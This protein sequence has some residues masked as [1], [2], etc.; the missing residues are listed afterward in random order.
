MRSGIGYDIHKLVEGREMFL[1]GVKI[2]FELGLLGHSDADVLLH[3][4]CDAL[5]GAA[6]RGDIGWH[7]P[8]S[9]VKYK[10]I[11]SL[12]LLERVKDII[13]PQYKIIN[14]DSVIVAEKPRLSGYIDEMKV[15]IA[16]TLDMDEGDL[17]IKAT[18]SEGLGVIGES[19]AVAAYAVSSLGARADY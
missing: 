19:R 14:I 8:P 2:P 5:L 3:A 9:D 17:N 7:F 1:G 4:I 12:K 11:S 18:T 13:E 6:G 15:N 16:N 10:D